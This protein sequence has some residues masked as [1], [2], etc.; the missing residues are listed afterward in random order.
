MNEQTKKTSHYYWCVHHGCYTAH[1]LEECILKD[2]AT[3]KGKSASTPPAQVHAMVVQEAVCSA[4]E[5]IL[6]ANK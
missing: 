4:L 5:E 1:K 6:E 3:D 2:K